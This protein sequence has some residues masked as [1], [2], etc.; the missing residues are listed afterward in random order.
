MASRSGPETFITRFRYE[1]EQ[2]QPPRCAGWLGHF[3]LHAYQR[4]MAVGKPG[5]VIL[6]TSLCYVI[7]VSG[8]RVG[9][10]PQQIAFVALVSYSLV[11]DGKHE[12]LW[13]DVYGLY[14][15]RF[16]DVHILTC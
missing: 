12:Q 6:L 4:S 14:Q 5:P 1:A 13:G 9:V 7:Y 2:H 11:L 15:D 16:T 3:V 8:R 10:S